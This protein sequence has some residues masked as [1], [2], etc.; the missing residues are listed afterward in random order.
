MRKLRFVI[1]FALAMFVCA[2]TVSPAMA[3]P[4]FGN[5]FYDGGVVR[6]VVP[7]ASAPKK[8]IDNLY[9]IPEGADGQPAG[10]RGRTGRSGLPRREM[11]GP[12]RHLGIPSPICLHPKRP[13]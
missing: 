13:F 6:T 10:C 9:V 2:M 12:D 1:V 8:G 4:G 11:G 3:K 5:L 7:P